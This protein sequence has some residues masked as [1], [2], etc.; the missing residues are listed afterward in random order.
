MGKR[1]V[2]G[3]CLAA[4]TFA[5]IACTGG[6]PSTGSAGSA[7]VFFVRP[8]N[9]ATIKTVSTI[10]FG[11]QGVTVAAV[12]PGELKPEQ[13]RP[14]TIHYHLGVDT[15]CLPAGTAIPKADPWIHFGDGKNVIEQQL[16]PGPH[17]LAVQAGDDMHRTIQGLCEVISVTVTE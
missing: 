7:R 5:M 4:V 6:T 14:S 2:L 17:R 10:E 9:G 13:V 8:T 12:P 16:T 1:V 3:M 15:D 11:S